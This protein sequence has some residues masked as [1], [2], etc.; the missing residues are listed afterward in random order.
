VPL[1]K[2]VDLDHGRSGT[3]PRC[4]IEEAGCVACNAIHNRSLG[5]DNTHYNKNCFMKCGFST[6]CAGSNDDSAVKLSED[7]E[8]DWHSLQALGVQFED[9]TTCDSSP[10]VCGIQ[11]IRLGLMKKRMLQNIKQ[12]SWMY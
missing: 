9:Y 5:T 3:A 10:E 4:Y 11:S 2:A 6:D 7:N 1:Q 12:H 8:D